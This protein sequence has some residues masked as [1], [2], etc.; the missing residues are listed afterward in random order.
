MALVR[1]IDYC[2]PKSVLEKYLPLL[3]VLS[4]TNLE[5]S[6]VY[7]KKKKKIAGYLKK[8]VN[9]GCECITYHFSCLIIQ[10][11]LVPSLLF[12]SGSHGVVSGFPAQRLTE[13]ESALVLCCFFS[14]VVSLLF[15]FHFLFYVLCLFTTQSSFF[16][17]RYVCASACV[18]VCVCTHACLD[19]AITEQFKFNR[20]S[21]LPLEIGA[22]FLG[23]EE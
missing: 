9:A 4:S 15:Q 17:L 23:K 1:L 3:S 18:R 12:A 21:N 14:L 8:N 5:A 13:Q 20:I 10:K 11:P 7:L 16:S 19:S 2:W 6:T 22:V